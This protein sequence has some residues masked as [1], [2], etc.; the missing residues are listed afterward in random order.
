MIDVLMILTLFV[1]FIAFELIQDSIP[2]ELVT[3]IRFISMTAMCIYI[4]LNVGDV[5]ISKTFM[6]LS[7]FT[8]LMIPVSIVLKYVEKIDKK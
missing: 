7:I 8:F 5:G 2:N 4:A 6:I 3:V 1:V